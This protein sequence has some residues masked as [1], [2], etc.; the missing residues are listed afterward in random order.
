MFSEK[1]KKGSATQHV[2]PATN[3]KLF[4]PRGRN[5]H[6]LD[7]FCPAIKFTRPS[8]AIS[9]DLEKECWKMVKYLAM[10]AAL[11]ASLAI[12]E[13]A[14]ARHGC[15]SCGGGYAGGYSG[16]CPGGTCSVQ[17]AAPGKMAVT[18]NAPPG[19]AAAPAP[20]SIPV[21]TTAQPTPTNYAYTPARRGLFGRR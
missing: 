11:L 2:L 19:L 1:P 13:N 10:V 5:L 8:L 3:E 14:F 6:P 20:A 4:M 17:Y 15:R 12:T 18:T 9:I 7:A 21:V 16:G